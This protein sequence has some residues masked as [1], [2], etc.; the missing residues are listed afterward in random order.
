MSLLA[1]GSRWLS[2]AAGGWFQ[3]SPFT[4]GEDDHPAASWLLNHR[5]SV[6]STISGHFSLNLRLSD[7]KGILHSWIVNNQTPSYC[8]EIASLVVSRS[9]LAAD[10]SFASEHGYAR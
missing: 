6:Y 8:A 1:A 5:S 4:E 2:G 3:A 10:N 9:I 7:S